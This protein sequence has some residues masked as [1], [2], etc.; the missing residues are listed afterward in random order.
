M[1]ASIL[2]SPFNA[3]EV[4]NINTISYRSHDRIQRFAGLEVWIAPK[5]AAEGTHFLSDV[6]NPTTNLLAIMFYVVA[7]H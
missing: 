1:N 2:L 4:Y 6:P 3:T 7:K 5:A